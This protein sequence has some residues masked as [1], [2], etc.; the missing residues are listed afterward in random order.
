[1]SKPTQIAPSILSADFANLGQQIHL[2][3]QAG[4]DWIHVDIMDG[5]FVPNLTFGPLIVAASRR[6]THLPL[7]VHLMVSEPDRLLP[8]F[9]QAGANYLSVHVETCPH[10]HRTLQT[11]R[12]LGCKPGV[13]LNPATPASAVFPVLHMLDLVLVMSV[14]PGFGGQTFIPQVLPKISELSAE[15][16]KVNP[17]I[18]LEIDGGIDYNTLPAARAAGIEV[19]VAGNAIFNHPQGIAAGI[20]ALRQAGV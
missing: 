10:L 15:I 14:N 1:M 2:A 16:Q 17:G 9:A 3:E 7:D 13:V 6:S 12:E 18:W 20:Q 19:F 11:I 8:A 5:H 4:A